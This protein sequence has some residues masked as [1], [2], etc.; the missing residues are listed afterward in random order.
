[1]AR[2]LPSQNGS[3]WRMVFLEGNAFA[4]PKNFVALGGSTP[5]LPKNFR[6]CR[7]TTL[8]SKF[9]ESRMNSALKNRHQ[10]LAEASDMN[11]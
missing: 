4:L 8:Q 2:F 5:A 9:P 11:S 10:P 6:S 3:E 1:M 7:S